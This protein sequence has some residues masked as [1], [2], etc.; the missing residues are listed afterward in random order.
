MGG[1]TAG[2]LVVAEEA[3][4]AAP[5]GHLVEAVAVKAVEGVV[6]AERFCGGDGAFVT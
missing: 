2:E 5:A 4:A 3:E 6:R 1:S